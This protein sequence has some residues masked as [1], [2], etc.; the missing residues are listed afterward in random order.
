MRNSWLILI[1]GVVGS[2]AT[3]PGQTNGVSPFTDFLIDALALSRMNLSLAYLLGTILSAITM[4]HAGALYDRYGS[5]AVGVGAGF[6]LGLSVLALS[7]IDTIIVSVHGLFPIASRAVVATAVMSAGFFL[8]R[9][10]GQ[11]TLSMASRNMVMKWFDHR[12]GLANA[13]LAPLS[14]LGFAY[15]PRAFDFMIRTW[16]WRGS[17]RIMALFLMTAFTLFALL[18]FSDPK[19]ESQEEHRMPGKKSW[20]FPIPER[21]RRSLRARAEI[22]P[23]R[24]KTDYTLAEAKK[25]L[26]FWLFNMT[27]GFASAVGTGFTFHVV[28]IFAAGSLS[29]ATALTIFF[30]ATV[31]AML[32]QF[33]G[34]AVSDYVRLKYFASIQMAGILIMMISLLILAPGAPYMLL[35]LGLGLTT[36]VFNINSVITWPRFFGLTH[37]GRISGFGFVWFVAGSA[38]GPYMYSLSHQIWASYKPAAAVFAVVALGLFVLS[39]LAENPNRVRSESVH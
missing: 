26:I 20:S 35:V 12:R 22:E 33:F 4:P 23:P 7:F 38:A 10:F 19:R 2:L 8:V 36:G 37:L 32:L 24:P 28:S 1:A 18:V 34:S 31:I 14:A 6:M 16:G 3:L 9:F 25:T 27:N 29:R 11:G 5:R 39:F 17:W 13:F 21:L 15:A 30:P